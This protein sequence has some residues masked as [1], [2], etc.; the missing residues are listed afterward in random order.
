MPVDIKAPAFAES[1]SEAQIGEWIKREGDYV[2]RDDVVLELETDK[3]ALEVVAP[4]SGTIV[5]LL[6]KVGET[7]TS[8]EIVAQLEP[9]TPP[10]GQA[11]PSTSRSNPTP[12]KTEAAPKA[13]AP[14]ATVETRVMPAARRAL[15]EKGIDPSQVAASGPGGRILKEDV[16]R[17]LPSDPVRWSPPREG[18]AKSSR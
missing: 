18:N 17:E 11:K 16:D 15:T 10:A 9:G 4:E 12:A 6:K 1:I 7:V 5:K 3:A 14:S 13:A 8:G 2:N